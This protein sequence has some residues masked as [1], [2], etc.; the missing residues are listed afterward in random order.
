MRALPSACIIVR[1]GDNRSAEI[2]REWHFGPAMVEQYVP[3]RELTVCVLEDRALVV[4]EILDGEKS[5]TI[6]TPNTRRAVRAMCCRRNSRRK[7]RSR[8]KDIAL[9]AHRALGCR[10]ASRADLRYDDATGRLVLLEVNTQPGMTP[11]SLLPEQAAP[12]GHGFSGALRL[13]GGAGG[14]PR[15]DRIRP[16]A[17]VAAPPHAPRAKKAAPRCRT[18]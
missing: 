9:A 17:D 10:G 4:T 13:D 15:V 16:H 5:S 1:P 6:I 11:T 18:G 14:M 12:C 3:G 8:R 7:S 2:V